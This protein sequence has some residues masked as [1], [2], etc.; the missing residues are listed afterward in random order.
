MWVSGFYVCVGW[1]LVPHLPEYFLDNL[2][3]NQLGT[4]VYARNL[5]R[6]IERIGF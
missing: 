3:P 6:E 4:E 5:V 1:E 2:H